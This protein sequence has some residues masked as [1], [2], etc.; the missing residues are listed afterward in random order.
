MPVAITLRVSESVGTMV[1]RDTTCG[2]SSLNS[3]S[4]VSLDDTSGRVAIA[5]VWCAWRVP[6]V[7]RVVCVRDEHDTRSW[8]AAAAE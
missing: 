8:A 7:R 3:G 1:E 6:C 4:S 2:P 5:S